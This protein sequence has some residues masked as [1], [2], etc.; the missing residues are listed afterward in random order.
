MDKRTEDLVHAANDARTFLLQATRWIRERGMPGVASEVER[1]CER[2]RLTADPF[3][4]RQ[5]VERSPV[6]KDTE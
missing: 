2:L 3:Y 6:L 1:H 4:E 5:S